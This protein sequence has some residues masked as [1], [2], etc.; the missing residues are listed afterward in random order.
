MAII[1]TRN[2]TDLGLLAAHS[3]KVCQKISRISGI[4]LMILCTVAIAPARSLMSPAV[5]RVVLRT[6]EQGRQALEAAGEGDRVVNVL[7]AAAII[8]QHIGPRP[9]RVEVQSGGALV[10]VA[11]HL[12]VMAL[13]S[14]PVWARR[15][16]SCVLDSA[17]SSPTMAT[18][19]A[20]SSISSIIGSAIDPF[21]VSKP[22]MNPAA[23]N[24]PAS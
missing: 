11:G 4:R 9:Q 18:G 7:R 2:R 8:V 6:V 13:C 5:G 16:P 10:A 1:N 22:T 24:N 21:S 15:R 14:R 20:V 19:I 17:Y 12:H 3:V 23:T